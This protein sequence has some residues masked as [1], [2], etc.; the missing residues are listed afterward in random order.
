MRGGHIQATLN[1]PW[2]EAINSDDSTFISPEDLPE[3]NEN[4]QITLDKQIIAYCR[5]GERSS[6]TWFVYKYLFGFPNVNNFD[7][8]WIEWGNLVNAPIE[9]QNPQRKSR[10]FRISK[11][12]E[13]EN[14]IL[15]NCLAEIIDDFKWCEGHEKLEPLLK[16][17]KRMPPLLEWLKDSRDRMGPRIHDPSLRS[18]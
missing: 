14:I 9:S 13:T 17:S 4:N 1:I 5:I 6:Y 8:L 7:G 18:S 11:L 3:L 10:N 2:S 15:P 12:I 16:F